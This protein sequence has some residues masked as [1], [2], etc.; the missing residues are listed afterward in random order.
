[1]KWAFTSASA[2]GASVW[3]PWA[4]ASDAAWRSVA[5]ARMEP[6]S[7][8]L[9]PLIAARYRPIGVSGFSPRAAALFARQWIEAMVP[10]ALP[11]YCLRYTSSGFS[12]CPLAWTFSLCSSLNFLMLSVHSN[13]S[14]TAMQ[15]GGSIASRSGSVPKMSV[16]SQPSGRPTFWAKLVSIS[17]FD[18]SGTQCAFFIFSSTPSGLLPSL[19]AAAIPQVLPMQRVGGRENCLPP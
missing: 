9:F 7:S 13:S 11:T 8:G 5:S 10:H 17:G 14:V 19:S 18:S 16:N 6:A 3:P 2:A 15:V 12:V 4:L 1:M